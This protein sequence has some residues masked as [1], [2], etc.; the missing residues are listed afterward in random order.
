[1]SAGKDGGAPWL[2][3]ETMG[4]RLTPDMKDHDTK[5]AALGCERVVRTVT[6]RC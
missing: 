3:G 6:M 1:M 2:S 4:S 5:W